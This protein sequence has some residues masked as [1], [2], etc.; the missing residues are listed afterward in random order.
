MFLKIQV[1][2]ISVLAFASTVLS[3]NIPGGRHSI[4][5][6]D[7]VVHNIFEDDAT[8]GTIDFVKN[9]GVC[10]TTPGVNQYSGYFS[11]G[12]NMSM[13]FWFFEARHNPQSAPLAMWVNGGPGCSS[14][15]G[16][17]QE[18]G[19]C[20]F[21]NNAS[22]PSLNPYSWNEYA[23][24]LYV[25]EPIGTGFSYGTE[26]VNGTVEAAPFVWKL[27]QSFFKKFPQYECRDFGLFTESYGG[28]YGP[29]FAYYF[30]E[31]NKAIDAGHLHAEK[32]DLVALGINNGWYDATIQEKEFINFSVNNSYYPLINQSIA[33]EY[34]AAYYKGC[35]PYLQEC[36]AVTGEDTVCS[37]ART[38]CGTVDNSFSSYYPDIDFYDIR[39]PS[40]AP[41]PPETYVNYLSDP[42]IMKAIGAKTNYSECTDSVDDLFGTTGDEL[43]SL[44]QSGIQVLIWA[45]DADAVCD[46]FGGFASTNA[47]QY[48]G[49]SEFVNKTVQNYTVDGVTKGTYKSVENLSWLR[50]FSSGHEI[51]AFQ[52]EVALQAF[53]QTM[54]K[55]SISST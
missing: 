44:V 39:Q 48:S 23:N 54:Q 22:T 25:D 55:K 43:S 4:E 9:S 40:S 26:T 11:V 50:V 27:L 8:G 51:P 45:G 6:R 46:W 16:L 29:G 47:I 30:E 31:Q 36:T 7:G 3:L 32:I 38:Q 5:E 24:M 10:E 37:N 20:Q 19:P 12:K 52:P 41:F 21:Y 2:A 33:D 49:T 34:L 15:I 17:F 1:L 18:N 13:W 53:K 35:L 14:M 42:A 28:H